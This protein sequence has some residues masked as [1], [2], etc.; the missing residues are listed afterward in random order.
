MNKALSFLNSLLNLERVHQPPARTWNLRRM[1]RLLQLFG[2]PERS[3]FS[4][5]VAG[6]K[7]K[8][9]TSFFLSEILRRSG[10]KTGLYHS[11]HLNGPHERIWI[12]GKP[13]SEKEFE[14]GL[15]KIKKHLPGVGAQ[16]TAPSKEK[17]AMNGALADAVSGF[18]YFEI[19]T[20][21]AANLFK[22]QQIKIAVF[23]AGMGGRLDATN[24]FPARMVLLTPIHYDH[25]AFLGNTLRKI[26]KEK[27]AIIK[28]DS[29]VIVSP[30]EKE[31]SNII[32]RFVKKN[33]A[34]Q[35][36]PAHFAGLSPG[37]RGDYQKLNAAMAVRA[38]GLLKEKHGFPI[39]E[40]A[41]RRGIASSHWPGRMELFKGKPAILLDGAHNPKSAAALA[42][43][44]QKLFPGRRKILIFGT[45]RDKRSD[46]I[47]SLLGPV[48][49]VG[50]MTQSRVSS[51]AKETAELLKEGKKHFSRLIPAPDSK[52]ALKI[53]KFIAQPGDLIVVTGSFYLIGELRP[54]V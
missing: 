39:A 48:F 46:W 43:N 31:V 2:H 49:E 5:L 26:A 28:P 24:A 32:R 41:V 53:A 52:E 27:A 15:L 11:P 44:L 22:E 1:R 4:V 38:A 45:S 29:D 36:G 33:K 37:L 7:G 18:T 51:R 10:I 34:R 23:E 13:V 8:G 40:D 3:F 42:R 16:F 30:Q 47:L 54:R 6:T 19:L 17:G 25:E 50:I 35:W 20:L 12:N 14:R 21:L 9:S